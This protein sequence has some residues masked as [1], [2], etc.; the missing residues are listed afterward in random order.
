[1]SPE[2][3]VMSGS[4]VSS[5]SRQIQSPTCSSRALREARNMV[6]PQV[7]QIGGRSSSTSEVCVVNEVLAFLVSPRRAFRKVLEHERPAGALQH[8]KAEGAGITRKRHRP[9]LSLGPEHQHA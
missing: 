9:A 6:T 4:L 7:A 2:P 3:Q 8:C 5:H 1:M